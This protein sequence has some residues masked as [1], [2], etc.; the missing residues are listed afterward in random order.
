MRCTQSATQLARETLIA[1]FANWLLVVLVE[2]GLLRHLVV[3]HGASKV[4]IAPRLV[5]CG[6][7]F[8]LKK[9]ITITCERL[10]Y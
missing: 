5:E 6:E 1:F 4:V 10:Q 3:A 9:Y 7:D 8:K 2:L